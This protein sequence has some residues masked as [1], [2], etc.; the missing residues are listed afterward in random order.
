MDDLRAVAGTLEPLWRP[1]PLQ[2]V[3]A[4]RGPQ[5]P[6]PARREAIWAKRDQV[7]ALFTE[8]LPNGR[9]R[10]LGDIAM[11]VQGLP[12]HKDDGS[13]NDGRPRNEGCRVV[14]EIIRAALTGV[15]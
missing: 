6:S 9:Y 10:S 3:Q 1:P 11:I 8:K 14:E 7:E 5:D 12:T 4:S 2:L 15:A 13:T